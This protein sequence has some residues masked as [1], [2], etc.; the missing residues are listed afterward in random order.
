MR[1]RFMRRAFGDGFAVGF[2]SLFAIF[3]PDAPRYS[4]RHYDSVARAWREVGDDLEEAMKAE[5]CRIVEASAGRHD[6]QPAAR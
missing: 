6:A 3:L 4:Y 1:S 5:E 2:T